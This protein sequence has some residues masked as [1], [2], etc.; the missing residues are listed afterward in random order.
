MGKHNVIYAPYGILFSSKREEI[1]I[2]ITT[3]LDLENI[4]H[5]E[6]SQSQKNKHCIIS[7]TLHNSTY[8]ISLHYNRAVKFTET[9]SRMVVARAGKGKIGNCSVV[10]NFTT[11][12]QE[13][14]FW[15]SVTQQGKHT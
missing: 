9:E 5:S 14:K 1:L 2:H 8:I 11:V 3:W 15:K 13:K 4:I 10:Q 6:M 12:L 7:L